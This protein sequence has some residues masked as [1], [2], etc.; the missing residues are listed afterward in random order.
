MNDL[1][2]EYIRQ[3][4]KNWAARH[5]P[6]SAERAHLLL[7]ASSYQNSRQEAPLSR[8]ERYEYIAPLRH[9]CLKTE[10]SLESITQTRIW[11][12]FNTPLRNMA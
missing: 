4:L 8:K 11:W 1:S 9:E 12:F 3:S 7:M 2:D 10:R 6:P 5:T